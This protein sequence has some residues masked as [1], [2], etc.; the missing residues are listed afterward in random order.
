MSRIVMMLLTAL[1]LC[2]SFMVMAQ[3]QG[4]VTYVVPASQLT[5]GQ[6]AQIKAGEA[7]TNL[8]QA[9]KYAG[10]GKEIGEGVSGALGAVNTEVAKFA[11]TDVGQ[12]TMAMIAWKIMGDDMIVVVKKLMGAIVGVPFFFL[13]SLTLLWSYRRL[14][15]PRRVMTKRGGGFFGEKEYTLIE[16]NPK[17]N[18]D[19]DDWAIAH[20][21]AFVA[22]IIISSLMIFA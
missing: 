5:E 11:D 18:W 3:E 21:V 2:S 9:G 4:G 6:I 16:P 17:G 13:T 8:E 1:M 15:F 20:A 12:F 22:V 14:C 7:L 10:I 19:V